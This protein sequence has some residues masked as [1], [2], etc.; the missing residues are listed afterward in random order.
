V[1]EAEV[2]AGERHEVRRV[3]EHAGERR[4]PAVV[5]ALDEPPGA[6]ATAREDRERI[7][8][9]ETVKLAA[10]VEQHPVLLDARRV[11]RKRDRPGVDDLAVGH[12]RKHRANDAAVHQR[13]HAQRLAAKAQRAEVLDAGVDRVVRDARAYCFR[14]ARAS[15]R[16]ERCA[17][18]VRST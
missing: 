18:R 6:A 11:G 1:P 15:R 4:T 12:A 16:R 5:D 7:E 10:V 13:V 8:P 17:R 9:V 2:A 3:A 14:A